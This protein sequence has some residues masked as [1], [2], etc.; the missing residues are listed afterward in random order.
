MDFEG[1]GRC[2]SVYLL[3]SEITEAIYSDGLIMKKLIV[4]SVFI[5]GVVVFSVSA[6]VASGLA[7]A[8]QPHNVHGWAF[9]SNIGWISFSCGDSGSAVDYGV[10]LDTNTGKFSGYA[11]SENI[12][13]VR[14]DPIGPYPESPNYSACV[15]L[16]A[17][18]G[19]KC[20][21][22]GDNKVSGWA[23]VCSVFASGCEGS[24]NSGRGGWDGW[25]KLNDGNQSVRLDVN[26]NPAELRDWG[27]GGNTDSEWQ[28]K[29]TVGWVSFNCLN[30]GLCGTSPY[31]V[32][33]D[34]AASVPSPSPSLLPSPSS[35]PP[36]PSPSPKPFFLPRWR[37][38]IPF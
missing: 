22:F 31:K 7:A 36:R 11:W 23:R 25:I 3:K 28:K 8:C 12:G 6:F 2:L 21:R 27:W 9:V 30:L 16:P 17:L 15:D 14:F 26:L 35:P 1:P 33:V 13:W 19:E 37:E 20:D 18:S 32:Q 29:A 4:F 5:I 34:I 10:D 38:I 24:L